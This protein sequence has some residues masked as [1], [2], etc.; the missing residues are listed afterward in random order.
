MIEI[1]NTEVLLFC[2]AILATAFAFKKAEEAK[3]SKGFVL[4]L[5]EHPEIIEQIHDAEKKFRGGKA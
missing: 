1:T 4:L 5:I 3:T 2:W